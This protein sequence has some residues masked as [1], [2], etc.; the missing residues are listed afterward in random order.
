M[1]SNKIIVLGGSFNPLTKA[2]GKI[3]KYLVNFFDAEK[4]ILLITNK[5]HN[6]SINNFNNKEILPIELRI[7][8]LN[9]FIKQNKNIELDLHEIDDENSTTYKS[10]NYLKEKY[11]DDE[12]LFVIGS[13]KLQN[14]DKWYRIDDILKDFKF[15]VVKRNN[16]VLNRIINENSFLKGHEKSFIFIDPSFDLTGISSTKIR[17]YLYKK[18][19][20]DLEK[21]TYDFVINILKE[22]NYL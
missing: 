16:G 8:I 7:K 11:K 15:I 5:I 1:R 10:L 22:N 3:I 12:I 18:D 21:L 19:E 17:E 2:H 6:H 20:K 9:E 13:E 4:G 14:L